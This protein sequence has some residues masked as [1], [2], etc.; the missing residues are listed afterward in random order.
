MK[1]EIK[2][3]PYQKEAIEAIDKDLHEKNLKSTLI[4]L[5]TGTGKTVVFCLYSKYKIM[6]GKAPIL[7]LAHTGVLTNQA[8]KEYKDLVGLDCGI[9]EGTETIE[10]QFPTVV[11]GTTQSMSQDKRLNRFGKDYFKYII[12]DEAHRALTNQNRKIFDYFEGAK[13]IGVTA[14]PERGDKQDLG[15]FFENLAYQY[16]IHQAVKD[17]YLVPIKAKTLPIDIDISGCFTT[18]GAVDQTEVGHAIEP[19]LEVIGEEMLKYCKTRKTVIFMPLIAT[20]KKFEIILKR[21]GFDVYEVNGS[22]KC[23]SEIIKSFDRAGKNSI[24]LNSMLLTEGW[25]CKSVDC[26]SVLRGVKSTGLYVQMIGRGTRLSPETGKK[27][28]LILDFLWHVEKHRLCSPASIV[29]K[30]KDIDDKMKAKISELAESEDLLDLFEVEEEAVSDA[31]QEREEAL[32]KQLDRQK[33]KK[34]KEVDVLQFEYS[35]NDD[36][37]SDYRPTFK[38]EFAP[39]SEAQIDFLTKK[40]INAET[41]DNAGKASLLI[42]KLIQRTKQNLTTPKQ[43]RALE[44]R[45]FAKVGMWYFEDAQDMIK[46]IA[47]NSW[48][49]N[50]GKGWG[51]I[52]LGDGVTPKTYVPPKGLYAGENK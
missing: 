46:K 27:D 17:G 22:T 13:V 43:I 39:P 11:V 10:G 42:D 35:I 37:L 16:S 51:K 28:L 20:S 2:P 50:W 9:E 49:C 6:Q 34:S 4:V 23:G 47:A 8:R 45:G 12:I 7:V 52:D 26:V 31:V 18:S 41:I 29:A 44:K 36:D 1:M 30:N 33:R 14:T 40:G 19:Y 38:T 5:P 21:L 32:A 48:R 15:L 24:M 25:N 3:R